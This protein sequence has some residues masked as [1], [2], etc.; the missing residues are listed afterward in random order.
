MAH[1]AQVLRERTDSGESIDT[2]CLDRGITRNKYF[3]WVR[4]L[5]EAVSEQLAGSITDQAQTGMVP[6]GF[7]EVK[8]SG[9]PGMAPHLDTASNSRLCID[10]GGVRITA[11]RSYPASQIAELLKWI[12]PPC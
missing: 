2:F 5:R 8:L 3:Y 11:D 9:P 1:W 4:K 10:L 12:M 7:A 6:R